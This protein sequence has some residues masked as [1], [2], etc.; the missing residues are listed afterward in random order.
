[1]SDARLRE[2]ERGW[3]QSGSVHDESAFLV[4]RL[5]QNDLGEEALAIAAGF[6]HPAAQLALRRPFA[7][8]RLFRG[9]AWRLA[10]L[11]VLGAVRAAAVVAETVSERFAKHRPGPLVPWAVAAL[12]TWL[13]D[14]TQDHLEACRQARERLVRRTESM[15]Y[16]SRVFFA[17]ETIRQALETATGSQLPL[18]RADRLAPVVGRVVDD[19]ARAYF[20]SRSEAPDEVV[21]AICAELGP[22][23]V[24]ARL[25][26]PHKS[27][28][29]ALL[30]SNLTQAR[31]QKLAKRAQGGSGPARRKL[32]ATLELLTVGDLRSEELDPDA[33][34]WVLY[35]LESDARSGDRYAAERLRGLRD[36][37]GQGRPNSPL[38]GAEA[39]RELNAENSRDRE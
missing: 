9:W 27:A 4:E 30:A 28:P 3:L 6:G 17:A 36:A 16:G 35:R 2:L 23:L 5:R 11:D 22:W 39:A 38:A 33:L 21:G 10:N 31:L 13:D 20:R 8:G 15:R 25:E 32:E 12:R 19:S 34:K 7:P 37:P 29:V 26:T 24:H 1:M 14:P 18:A